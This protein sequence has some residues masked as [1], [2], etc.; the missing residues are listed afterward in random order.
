MINCI[1][2][3]IFLCGPF[4]IERRYVYCTGNTLELWEN[5][6]SSITTEHDITRDADL[7]NLA[8]VK[9]DFSF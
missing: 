6:V 8:V 2:S 4:N 9:T 7:L 5:G 1:S 3:S